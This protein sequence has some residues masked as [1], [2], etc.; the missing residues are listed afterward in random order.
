MNLDRYSLFVITILDRMQML[1]PD[2]EYNSEVEKILSFRNW[3]RVMKGNIT[4]LMYF[5]FFYM[6]KN[7]YGWMFIPKEEVA[8][9]FIDTCFC[10]PV[11]VRYLYSQYNKQE[12]KWVPNDN[13][14]EMD[15]L[16]NEELYVSLL[17]AGI[18][19]NQPAKI[20]DLWDNYLEMF[21]DGILPIKDDFFLYVIKKIDDK[22]Y[23]NI[24]EK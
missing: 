5:P 22:V 23:L 8:I 10:I 3:F 20:Q 9:R 11:E 18:N 21:P 12:N 1:H 13:L 15:I 7:I 2:H 6:L 24:K 4:L 16:L 19:F 17:G 14:E